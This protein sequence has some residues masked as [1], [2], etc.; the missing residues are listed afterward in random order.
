MD[1]DFF[2]E[3]GY[4]G[5]DDECRDTDPDDECRDTDPDDEAWLDED[6]EE[7]WD[8]EALCEEAF[9]DE[10]E[11]DLSGE[12]GARSDREATGYDAMDALVLGT[13]IAGTA[14]DDARRNRHG[15]RGPNRT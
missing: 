9:D 4:D 2:D 10:R 3:G 5:A 6:L 14:N 7:E 15:K 11:E 13:M 8:E 1:D 12:G